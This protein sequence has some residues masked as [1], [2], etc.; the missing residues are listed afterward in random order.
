MGSGALVENFGASHQSYSIYTSRPKNPLH[1]RRAV[2]GDV[3][4]R[5]VKETL[6]YL[7]VVERKAQCG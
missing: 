3:D 5:P 6:V 7:A 2:K 4:P 1:L